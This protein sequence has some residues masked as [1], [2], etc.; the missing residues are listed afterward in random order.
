MSRQERPGTARRILAFVPAAALMVIIFLFSAQPAEEST[1]VS[2]YIGEKFYQ[3]ANDLFGFGW[4]AEMIAGL[5]LQAQHVIRKIAH[6]LEYLLLAA[7]LFHGFRVNLSAREGS[8]PR[9]LWAAAAAFA[10]ILYAVSDEVHQLFVPG[11]SGMISDV[12]VDWGGVLTG[13]LL[14]VLVVTRRMHRMKKKQE[15]A[16]NG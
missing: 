9:R 14:S 10:G 11:R 4:S 3:A 6:F 7:M 8:D 12:I 13:T 15:A 1:E 16:D 2:V 5:T